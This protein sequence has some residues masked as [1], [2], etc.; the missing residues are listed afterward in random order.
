[1]KSEHDA[2]RAVL[3]SI[4]WPPLNISFAA[5]VWRVDN[6]IVPN[7][8]ADTSHHFSIIVLLDEASNARDS[9]WDAIILFTQFFLSWWLPVHVDGVPVHVDNLPVKVQAQ[10]PNGFSAFSHDDW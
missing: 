3:A 7:S 10:V 5:P 2:I 6:A 8:T 9:S 4:A 1:V